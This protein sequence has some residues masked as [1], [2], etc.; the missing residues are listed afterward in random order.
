MGGA[1][2]GV[3]GAFPSAVASF[4]SREWRLLSSAAEVEGA[5]VEAEALGS[6][7]ESLLEWDHDTPAWTSLPWSEDAASA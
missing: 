3:A 4:L 5:D 2:E 6:V 1:E 7:Y